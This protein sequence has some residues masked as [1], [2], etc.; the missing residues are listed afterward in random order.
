MKK[1]NVPSIDE[2]FTWLT[3]NKIRYQEM[4][5]WYEIQA[6]NY[7]YNKAGGF[8]NKAFEHGYKGIEIH[9]DKY[10]NEDIGYDYRRWYEAGFLAKHLEEENGNS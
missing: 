8:Y 1:H 3:K 4:I 9:I 10:W 7:V 6:I 2:I 5:V